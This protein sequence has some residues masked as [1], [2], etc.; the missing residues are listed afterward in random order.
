MTKAKDQTNES[1]RTSL[2]RTVDAAAELVH[3]HTELGLS[4][5]HA[6]E[7]REPTGG[8]TEYLALHAVVDALEGWVERQ[9]PNR[10]LRELNGKMTLPEALAD[11]IEAA[12]SFSDALQGF[13][14]THGALDGSQAKAEAHVPLGLIGALRGWF[15]LVERE[16][17]GRRRLEEKRARLAQAT[18]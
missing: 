6:D 14:R 9:R 12:R 1:A 3:A 2:E 4:V 15:R 8:K 16:R 18:A 17:D 13:K 11:T 7:Y 10:R 5:K